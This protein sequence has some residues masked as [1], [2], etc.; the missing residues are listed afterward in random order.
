MKRYFSSTP[1]YELETEYQCPIC[2]QMI[3]PTDNL[4]EIEV[5][6]NGDTAYHIACIDGNFTIEDGLEFIKD[7]DMEKEFFVEYRT[8]SKISKCS[9]RLL[10]IC[11][12]QF[13]RELVLAK[14]SRENGVSDSYDDM[15]Q[16]LKNFCLDE[17][18]EYMD[19]Y[20][21]KQEE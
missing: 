11:K 7:S 8:G 2:Q 4:Y 16:E 14:V 9:K 12:Y 6:C 13:N 15:E 20:N 3:C 5:I 17:M 10:Q 1:L 21:E 19:W 18:G